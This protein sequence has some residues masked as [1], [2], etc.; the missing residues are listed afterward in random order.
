MFIKSSS[1]IHSHKFEQSDKGTKN[2]TIIFISKLCEDD[3]QQYFAPKGKNFP[4]FALE[5]LCTSYRVIRSLSRRV[6]RSKLRLKRVSSEARLRSL[7]IIIFFTKFRYKKMKVFLCSL[8]E[9]KQKFFIKLHKYFVLRQSLYSARSA[10][11][12][13]GNRLFIPLFE[14]MRMNECEDDGFLSEFYSDDRTS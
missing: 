1:W 9:D 13:R 7:F 3:G 4:N 8:C 12:L 2:A 11:T 14:F 10:E 5:G 6:K